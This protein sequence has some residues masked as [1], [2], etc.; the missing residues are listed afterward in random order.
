MRERERA[1]DRERERERKE[2]RE[3]E[4]ER[5][6]EMQ[7]E[8]IILRMSIHRYIYIHKNKLYEQKKKTV[9]F[10]DKKQLQ[11]LPT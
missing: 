1:R 2:E 7:T 4:I 8:E 3:R 10:R 6:R 11:Q 5:K 9:N